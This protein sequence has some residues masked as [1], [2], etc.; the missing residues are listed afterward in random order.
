MRKGCRTELDISQV[1]GPP[2][3]EAGGGREVNKPAAKRMIDSDYIL[4][5]EKQQ[6][7]LEDFGR[8]R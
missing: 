5:D 8:T 2:C 4:F 6:S 7:A 3:E 1:D